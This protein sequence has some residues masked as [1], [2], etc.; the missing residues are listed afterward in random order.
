MIRSKLD[1]HM[2]L[3]I[4]V[5][6]TMGLLIFYRIADHG[7]YYLASLGDAK[8]QYVHFFNLFHD[9]V[10]SGELPFWSWTYGPG[11][12]FWNDFG[13]YMLGD[14]FIWPLLLL[15]KAW[16]P[17][18]FIP[19]TILKITLI[20]LG[21]YLLLKKIGI[22]KWISFIAGIA[23]SF[24]LFNFDHFYTHYF[25]LNAAVYFPFVLLGYERFLSA[26]KPAFLI[27]VLFLASISNFY[28]LFMI[29]IGLFFYSIFR[30]FTFHHNHGGFK[31]FFYFHIKLACVY[32]LSLGTAMVIFLPS[33]IS[34]FHSNVF[35]RP[36]KASIEKILD[37]SELLTKLVWQGGMS[38][39]PLI[40]LPLV[41][42]NGLKRYWFHAL[43][44]IAVFLMIDFQE[45]NSLIA[46]LSS[47]FEFRALFLYNTLL[48]TF[49]AVVLNEMDFT[50]IKN[51][52]I[53]L[54]TS[55][56]LSIWLLKNPFTHYAGYIEYLP[57]L[58]AVLFIFSQNLSAIGAKKCLVL[59]SSLTVI[60]YSLLLPYSLVTDL[61]TR[62]EGGNPG[63]SHKGVWGV[64]PLLTKNDY[65]HYYNNAEVKKTLLQLKKDHD[66]YRIY[67][68]NPQ[69]LGNNSSLS[70][71]FRSFYSYNSLL[72]WDLQSFEMDT[73]AQMGSRR[74]NTLK[75]YPNDTFVT[76]LLNNKYSVSFTGTKTQL[77]GYVPVYQKDNIIIEK[78]KYFLP[79]G[80]LYNGAISSSEFNQM[81]GSL[82][83]DIMLKN[84]VVSE[85]DYKDLDLPTNTKTSIEIAGSL[86]QAVFNSPTKV[87]KKEKGLLI[88]SR[89]PIEITIPVKGHSLSDLSVFA[90]IV[91][92][93]T[94]HGITMH[95]LNNAG[96]NYIFEKN[97]RNNQY[98]LTQY[99]YTDT[100]NKVI[101]HFGKDQETK[102]IKL[103]LQP[104]TFVLKDIRVTLSSYEDY[105]KEI[106][107]YQ[108][109][110]LKKINYGN[111][112]IKGHYNSKR[113]SVLFL[114]IPYSSGW[115]ASIDGKKVKTFPVHT[116]FM[117]I[118]AP[119]GS[120]SV[121]LKFIP[122]GFVPGLLISIISLGTALLVIRKKLLSP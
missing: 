82:H 22:K 28:F 90:D 11:G 112:F 8:E 15:P 66:F 6:V 60:L 118:Y 87:K 117:G 97:M 50:R 121:T 2:V 41:L 14:I 113:N 102:W 53:L 43:M 30:Y 105:K 55:S 101:F 46:G 29:T 88:S 23:N 31:G 35:H 84:A 96:K 12:S 61:L 89:N 34:L 26:K 120:H 48:I 5:T 4:A 68:N 104:G 69:V 74:I 119:K 110:S 42:V 47:P 13:Y 7:Y 65:E 45:I 106:K 100:T 93:T 71:G 52:V 20:S 63:N 37:W 10:R 79:V 24:A 114:S 70:Y 25:F 103:Q 64:L 49:S 72:K 85:S 107:H 83:D 81:N 78:N 115:K 57:A 54:L 99:Y 76:T 19:I 9:L 92:Y 44:I 32:L 122:E 94:N 59:L 58:F 73:L 18:S 109:D 77:Y 67:P 1:M 27:G 75:G 38:F 16:F 40:V 51:I 111:N 39:L 91:P 108:K 21:T 56:L 62:T 86:S 3:L 116:A 36:D 33:V 17:L 95:A 80:F 98:A